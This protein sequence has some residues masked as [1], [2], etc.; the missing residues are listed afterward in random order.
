M[1]TYELPTAHE[2]AL[3]EMV[4]AKFHDETK[5]PIDQIVIEMVLLGVPTL[6]RAREVVDAHF[7]SGGFTMLDTAPNPRLAL[8]IAF[9]AYHATNMTTD[10]MRELIERTL[11]AVTIPEVVAELRRQVA[12]NEAEAQLLDDEG[13]RRYGDDWS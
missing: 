11:P 12:F 9:D 8:L 1:L 7:I 4:M 5:M 2:R 13:R 3:F 10:E 6:D